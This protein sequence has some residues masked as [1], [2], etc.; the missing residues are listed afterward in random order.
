MNEN[1][2]ELSERSQSLKD[3]Q[4][5]ADKLGLRVG[6]SVSYHTPSLFT[7]YGCIKQVI[8]RPSARALVTTS[9][10]DHWIDANWLRP[11]PNVSDPVSRDHQEVYGTAPT[12]TR[13]VVVN[14]PAVVLHGALALDQACQADLDS[15]EL[16]ELCHSEMAHTAEHLL[17]GKTTPFDSHPSMY[18]GTS[19]MLGPI[20]KRVYLRHVIYGNGGHICD[21][22]QLLNQSWDQGVIPEVYDTDLDDGLDYFIRVKTNISAR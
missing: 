6:A 11:E 12:E 9:N 19:L 18:C 22:T 7:R 4:L 5:R 14:L 20:N 13:E 2:R 3:H 15:S 16:K 21:Y 10:G 8:L 17:W 1:E